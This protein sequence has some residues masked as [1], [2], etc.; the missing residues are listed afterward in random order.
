MTSAALTPDSSA[1]A[2]RPQGGVS[3]WF[4]DLW[5]MT[6]RNIRYLVRSPEMVLYSLLQPVLFI[7]LFAY[8]FGGAIEVGG[9]YVQFLLPGIFVQ[10][11]LYGSATGTTIGVAAE[12]RTGLMDRF[13]S[14]PMS[15]TAVL[16]GRTVSE[17]F[18]TVA[19]L[20]VMVPIGLLM[21]FRFENGF[22]PA[23]GGML[24]LL[25]FGHAVSWLGAWIGLSVHSAQAA[26]AAGG[27]WVFPFVLISSAFVPTETM[28]GWLQVY[29]ANSPMT[30]AVNA[31][32]ALFTGGPAASDVLQTV[33][34]SFGLIVV[35]GWLSMR[36]FESLT[37]R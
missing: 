36:K 14:M 20:A 16:L 30:T 6:L 23:L 7:L 15:R 29:A 26:Q 9:D 5:E 33:A 4:S 31:L 17:V 18:R 8:V 34:W 25:L 12:M 2:A 32:R 22:L 28:P 37:A 10:M 11:A 13:R 27:V 35:F 21:G 1:V 3:W 24:L 19:S